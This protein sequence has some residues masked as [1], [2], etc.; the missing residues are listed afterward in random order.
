MFE[1]AG[2]HGERGKRI[3]GDR[4][5]GT[6]ELVEERGFTRRR[7]TDK[8]GSRIAGRLDRVAFPAPAVLY[9]TEDRF[10]AKFCHL[11]LDPPDVL[12]GSLVVRSLCQLLASSSA[13]CSSRLPAISYI[14]RCPFG[15]YLFM[16]KHREPNSTNNRGRPVGRKDWLYRPSFQVS[17]RLRLLLKRRVQ[18]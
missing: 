1:G 14:N 5:L 15:I 17:L 10:V 2:H 13:I 12:G 4:T 7:E 16:G 6:G 3:C 8:N 9:R 18:G 11:R